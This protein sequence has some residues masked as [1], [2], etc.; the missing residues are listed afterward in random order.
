MGDIIVNTKTGIKSSITYDNLYSINE[1]GETSLGIFS[2]LK[3]KIKGTNLKFIT[4]EVDP[5]ILGI[6][7]H[8][9]HLIKLWEE[10][11]AKGFPLEDIAQSLYVLELMQFIESEYR[12]V[13]AVTLL[14]EVI[15]LLGS[16]NKCKMIA[17][18]SKKVARDK[19]KILSIVKSRNSDKHNIQKNLEVYKQTYTIHNEYNTAS[20]INKIVPIEFTDDIG[21]PDFKVIDTEIFIDTKM[22]LENNKLAYKGPAS[23]HLT[24][25]IVLSLLMKDGFAPLQRTFD[26]QNSDI[27]MINLSLSAYG[28]ILS[29]GLVIDSNFIGV[30][31]AALDMAR[32]KEKVVIF[33]SS[34]RG[35]IHKVFAICFKRSTVDRIGGDLSEIDSEL[36]RL[37]NEKNFSQFASYVN[38]LDLGSFEVSDNSLRIRSL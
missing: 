12:S 4:G 9:N 37:G 21:Q 35:T 38:R 18:F 5:S 3:P 24:N 32:N 1:K 30:L 22:R 6:L 20:Y 27:A 28:F 25:G 15:V 8:P 16:I 13:S 34:P 31:E 14:A 23:L 7:S 36:Y 29:T 2:P 11:E 33:Y 10:Y 26:E 17:G 19:K